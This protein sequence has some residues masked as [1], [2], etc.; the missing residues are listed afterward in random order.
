MDHF[1]Q[2]GDFYG[3][4]DAPI[5]EGYSTLSYLAAVTK[6]IRAG[7]DVTAAVYRHP[8]VLI[9]TVTTLATY[10]RQG[11]ATVI[12]SKAVEQAFEHGQKLYLLQRQMNKS[13][14]FIKRWVSRITQSYWPMLIVMTT[15]VKKS[16]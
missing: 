16:L 12:T 10:R 11:I 6:Q 2:I 1:F 7:L 3:P 15:V 5:L 4:V 8:G 14:E 9:K 13:A